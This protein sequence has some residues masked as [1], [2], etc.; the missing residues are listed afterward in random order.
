M[1]I[2]LHFNCA[3]THLAE[4]SASI[5]LNFNGTRERERDL[6]LDLTI[7]ND[8]FNDD[9]R[10]VSRN[11]REL[12]NL[13]IYRYAS[14]RWAIFPT[15]LQIS[16]FEKETRIFF[17]PLY[18]LFDRVRRDWEMFK[19]HVSYISYICNFQRL[20]FALVCTLHARITHTRCPRRSIAHSCNRI[21]ANKCILSE[22]HISRYLYR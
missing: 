21:A 16:L 22:T 3:S 4:C 2:D 11:A 18:D 19:G 9:A 6:L 10:V 20:L 15:N 13:R 7:E 14:R 8:L 1:S 17:A 5:E 12:L